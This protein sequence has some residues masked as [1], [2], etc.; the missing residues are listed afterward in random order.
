MT[1]LNR[2][3]Q[4]RAAKATPTGS[5]ATLEPRSEVKNTRNIS[6][7]KYEASQRVT[8]HQCLWAVR[9]SFFLS[10]LS[11]PG[12]ALLIPQYGCHWSSWAGCFRLS[13]LPYIHYFW[14]W[15]IGL[16]CVTTRLFSTSSHGITCD[17]LKPF[18]APG[19]SNPG[20]CLINFL[21]SRYPLNRIYI[22][23]FAYSILQAFVI[24]SI[25][26]YHSLLALYSAWFPVLLLDLQSCPFPDHSLYLLNLS[27]LFWYHL[28]VS[29]LRLSSCH[30]ISQIS[31]FSLPS[32]A[33]SG[34]LAIIVLS[35]VS[36][37][38]HFHYL[39]T[40]FKT[41]PNNLEY[42]FKIFTFLLDFL[43]LTICCLIF[44]YFDYFFILIMS[45]PN[46]LTLFVNE[47]SLV[48]LAVSH[49]TIFF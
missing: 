8:V 35:Q 17:P 41:G 49:R 37:L 43:S 33:F 4:R 40:Y 7:E 29:R 39:F 48:C 45:V 44:I 6:P 9:P 46:Y 34:W 30:P 32:L 18:A 20:Y 47:L 3:S 36:Q 10:L 13:V 38:Y 19:L 14:S 5:A 11:M 1:G 24:K 25:T 2:R 26:L 15:L 16:T 42:K 27:L 28:S 21:A 23:P 22:Y 31:L 12:M